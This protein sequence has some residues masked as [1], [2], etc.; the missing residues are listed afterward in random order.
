MNGDGIND[1]VSVDNDGFIRIY[2]GRYT[3]KA[4]FVLLT[5]LPIKEP[6]D[7]IETGDFNCDGKIDIVY[8]G[9][10]SRKITILQQQ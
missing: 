7:Y 10:V 3:T 6:V 1:V 2:D 5:S 8:L 9:S 4:K